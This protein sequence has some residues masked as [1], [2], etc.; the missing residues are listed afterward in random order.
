MPEPTASELD[1]ISKLLAGEDD[2]DDD[3]QDDGAET[4]TDDQDGAP[5]DDSHDDDSEARAETRKS[6]K[7]KSLEDAAERLGIEVAD[8]YALEIPLS[9]IDDQKRAVKL[10][11]LKASRCPP[12]SRPWPS[13]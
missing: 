5:G 2:Q 6:G 7:P 9:D 3:D 12:R 10:G 4:R 1:Q 11:E 8:L 13:G